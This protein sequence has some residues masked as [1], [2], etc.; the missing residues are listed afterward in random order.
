MT[1]QPLEYWKAGAEERQLR[2]FISHRYEKDQALY[3][4]VIAALR[5][6]GHIVQNISLSATQILAGPKGG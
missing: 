2:L 4:E 1:S 6:E 3:D 5:V